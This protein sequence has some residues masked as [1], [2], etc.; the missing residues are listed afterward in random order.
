MRSIMFDLNDILAKAELENDFNFYYGTNGGNEII[1][2]TE[3]YQLGT[4]IFLIQSD[5][6]NFNEDI[7][8]KYENDKITYEKAVRMQILNN[9]KYLVGGL[10]DVIDMLENEV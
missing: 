10:R 8:D 5:D 1:G 7:E 4:D 3:V 6:L 9:L 2:L